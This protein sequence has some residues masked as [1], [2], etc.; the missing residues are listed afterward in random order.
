[1]QDVIGEEDEDDEGEDLF[2]P[3]IDE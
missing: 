1:V 3:G 2:G